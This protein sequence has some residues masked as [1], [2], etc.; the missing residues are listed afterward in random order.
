[1]INHMGWSRNDF[2][3]DTLQYAYEDAIANMEKNTKKY[4]KIMLTPRGT[5]LNQDIVKEFS[6]SEGLVIVCGRYEGVDQI[7]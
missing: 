5:R 1:M 3:A 6:K 7:Y 4:Q 2:V